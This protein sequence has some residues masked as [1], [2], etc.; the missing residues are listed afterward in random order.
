M[1]QYFSL[2]ILV[3]ILFL[4]PVTS[5]ADYDDGSGRPPDAFAER[6]TTNS[7]GTSFCKMACYSAGVACS[8]HCLTNP[9]TEIVCLNSCRT[10]LDNCLNACNKIINKI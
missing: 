10:A 4:I 5:F 7:S 9:A 6:L 2:L 1:R 8:T 3:I